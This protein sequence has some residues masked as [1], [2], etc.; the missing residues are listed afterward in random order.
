MVKK[1]MKKSKPKK[2]NNHICEQSEIYK[3]MYES[4]LRK[5]DDIY[6]YTNKNKLMQV[7]GVDK[8]GIQ[9]RLIVT[10][11]I[12]STNGIFIEVELP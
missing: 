9:Y 12:D 8:D 6:K 10:K 11:F 3:D 2:K 5:I 1:L 7:V 4:A